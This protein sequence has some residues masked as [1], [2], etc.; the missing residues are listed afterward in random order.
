MDDN[1]HMNI[2]VATSPLKKIL[3]VQST[4]LVFFLLL[5]TLLA[6]CAGSTSEQLEVQ[7]DN[8]VQ[9]SYQNNI[10]FMKGIENGS[11]IWLDADPNMDNSETM[12]NQS[13]TGGYS[14]ANENYHEDPLH[15]GDL[16]FNTSR[17]LRIEFTLIREGEANSDSIHITLIAGDEIIVDADITSTDGEN[18]SYEIQMP[19]EA[20]SAEAEISFEWDYS[21]IGQTNYHFY[22]DGSSFIS[23]PIVSTKPTINVNSHKDLDSVFGFVKIEGEG[24][25][26]SGLAIDKVESF[27]QSGHWIEINGT[28]SWY[29]IFNSSKYPDGLFHL[30]FRAFNGEEYSDELNLT[31][32]IEN[33]NIGSLSNNENNHFIFDNINTL[34]ALFLVA[35]ILLMTLIFTRKNNREKLDL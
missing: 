34:T 3:K 7:K 16:N 10:L 12:H 11:T 18:Y 8:E 17:Y 32:N 25:N 22:T 23:L 5:I 21:W 33:N 35:L 4:F 27:V 20:I 13:W 9:L 26:N 19:L 31:L 29:Y 15:P 28:T 6:N 1:L 30:K 24:M 14:E 2:I